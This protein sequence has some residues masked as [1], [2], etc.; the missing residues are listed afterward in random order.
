VI[1]M[2]PHT[3][4]SQPWRTREQPY[5]RPRISP[6]DIERARREA[7]EAE[8][9][10]RAAKWICV[11]LVSVCIVGLAWLGWVMGGQG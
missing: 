6:A 10:E 1:T 9:E 2:T 5:L 4:T 11:F 8:A 3:K 7:E